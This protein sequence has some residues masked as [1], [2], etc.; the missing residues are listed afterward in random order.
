MFM[1]FFSFFSDDFFYFRSL[2]PR[3]TLAQLGVLRHARGTCCGFFCYMAGLPSLRRELRG[4]FRQ[5]RS[6]LLER[7]AALRNHWVNII[8]VDPTDPMHPKIVGSEL[9]WNALSGL[10]VIATNGFVN[11]DLLVLLSNNNH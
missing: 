1:A 5:P 3:P 7:K 9:H 4:Y 10:R 11:S 8:H 6:Q 2:K